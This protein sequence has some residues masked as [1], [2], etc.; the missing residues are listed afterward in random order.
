MLD[1]LY[2]DNIEATGNHLRLAL[3][4]IARHK[5][6]YNP[7]AYAVWYE[8]ASGRNPEL[9]KEIESFEKRETPI[10][11]GTILG[12]FRTYIADHQTILAEKRTREFRSIL[13][14]VSRHI[15]DSG[16]RLSRKGNKIEDYTGQLTP[17]TSP[18]EVKT[19]SDGILSETRSIIRENH[20]LK[21]DMD[22]TITEIDALKKELEGMK[23]AAK[24]DM[25]TGLLNRRGFDEAVARVLEPDAGGAAPRLT[26]IMTDIDHFK[27]VNDTH[28]H[29][30]G[31]NV[32]KML[33]KLLKDHIK[34]KDIAARF[35]GEEFIL[36]LPDTRLDGGRT[37]AEQIRTS[38]QNIRWRTKNSG[39]S[40]GPI[41]VS[42]GL[43][44][45][46]PGEKL[47]TLIQRADNAL[48]WAKGNGRNQTITE[49]DLEKN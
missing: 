15:G 12:W 19:V 9:N 37:L 38:L 16:E 22:D 28:G 30:I 31:D 46:R 14:E 44:Q 11:F 21:Q 3:Q 45:Y 24:T 40:I 20:S 5:L 34:G 6:P 35:G 7:I 39:K 8:Y 29:L 27:Q 13:T 26:V 32:L 25:L 43:A 23:Q 41:T 48:Y 47:E 33:S 17:L 36:V 1:H 2:P 4:H 10:S 49:R 42:L 18:A